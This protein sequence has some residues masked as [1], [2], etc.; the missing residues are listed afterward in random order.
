MESRERLIVGF[1]A[2]TENVAEHARSKLA[3]KR[4]DMIVANDVTREGAGFDVDT[5]IVTL[6][7]REG[8]EVQLPKMSKLDVAH[9][10]LDELLRLRQQQMASHA[11]SS[12][13]NSR[14]NRQ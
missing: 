8:P 14:A 4:A 5:N 13:P 3:A 12:A 10:V 2:E 1:A 6:F 9:R 11:S 7:F